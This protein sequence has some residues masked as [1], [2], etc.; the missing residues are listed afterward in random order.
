M[1]G[2]ER[3]DF[4]VQQAIEEAR[5][6]YQA[7]AVPEFITRQIYGRR[8]DVDQTFGHI[9]NTDVNEDFLPGNINGLDHLVSSS[10][11]DTTQTII[12]VGLTYDSATNN[13]VRVVQPVQLTGRTPAPLPT[14]LVRVERLR[15]DFNLT[16][17]VYCYQSSNTTV[18]SGVPND[19]TKVGCKI[20][21]GDNQSTKAYVCTASNEFFVINSVY[22]AINRRQA[23]S[24]NVRFR[25]RAVWP[26]FTSTGSKPGEAFKTELIH[27]VHSTGFPLDLQTQPYILLPPGHEVLIEADASTNNVDISGGFLGYF[28]KII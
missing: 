21:L 22:A 16:G 19:L 25:S 27:G 9:N 11:S 1:A 15:S 18:S 12:V 2:L 3:Y 5:V 7:N 20:T 28:M 10:N 4:P 13:W 14:P 23:A 17:D 26:T 8:E 24:A 6:L